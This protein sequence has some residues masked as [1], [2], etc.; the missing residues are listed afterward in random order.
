MVDIP[1]VSKLFSN[2]PFAAP[3]CDRFTV[4][5]TW[6]TWDDPE[7]PYAADAGTSQRIIMD[8]GDWDRSVAVN[9]S[10]QSE[11]L[12]HEHREDLITMWRDLKYHP[13]LFT[14][15]AVESKAAAALRLVPAGAE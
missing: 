8:A 9:S 12:F 10:G 3:G 5:A 7:R 1:V 15:Q 11:L 6:F 2:G 4:N 13:L 14:R